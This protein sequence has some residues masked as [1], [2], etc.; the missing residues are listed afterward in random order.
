[1]GM[2]Q[3]PLLHTSRQNGPFVAMAYLRP[4]VMRLRNDVCG[5]NGFSGSPV[6]YLPRPHHSVTFLHVPTLCSHSE[7]A[8]TQHTMYGF[9]RSCSGHHPPEEATPKWGARAPPQVVSQRWPLPD[10]EDAGLGA[11]I[12]HGGRNVADGEHVLGA[13]G[14]LQ[15]LVD[16]DEAQLVC[17]ECPLTLCRGHRHVLR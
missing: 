16:A 1:M 12:L 14:G 4:V 8:S 10:R 17:I 7:H 13:A 3:P 9:K 2:Q 15:E 11:W 5:V 6:R